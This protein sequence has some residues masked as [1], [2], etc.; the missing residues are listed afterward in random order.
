MSLTV[1]EAMSIGGL[2]SSRVVSGFSGL[3]NIIEHVSVIEIPESYHW[4][5]GNELFLTAFYNS[6]NDVDIQLKLL[7]EMKNKNSAALAVCYPGRYYE[8][9]LPEF[10][11]VAEELQI[12]VIEVPDEVA[13]SDII[14]PINQRIFA[15]TYRENNSAIHR[16]HMLINDW[17]ISNM[18]S[19]EDVQKFAREIHWDVKSIV[20]ISL[21]KSDDELKVKSYLNKYI[22][23]IEWFEAGNRLGFFI[24]NL[25]NTES[26]Y[27]FRERIAEEIHLSGVS[28]QTYIAYDISPDTFIES[29]VSSY[30]QLEK[31]LI[32]QTKI[33]NMPKITAISE[34][35]I[36]PILSNCNTRDMLSLIEP[37]ELYEEQYNTELYTTFEHL[38]FIDNIKDICYLLKIHR[39][40]LTY[41]RNKIIEILN[42]DPFQR[43]NILQYQF[44]VYCKYLS[45]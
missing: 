25:D 17:L 2:K 30:Q 29:A 10:I 24:R 14:S 16:K 40:T 7:R 21:L 37:I 6:G 43:K 27:A 23:E 19:G 36:L 12:P 26:I 8:R 18:I 5:R 35:P 9:I 42:T 34:Y 41:R 1:K 15:P 4:F 22:K 44:A 20:G 31:L 45:N 38:L 13:Y 11:K 3:N 32:L 33:P 28:E 39:N